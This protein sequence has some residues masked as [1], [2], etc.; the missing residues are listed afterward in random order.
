MSSR[1]R[2][3]LI[4]VYLGPLP[5][6][7]AYF[8]RSAAANPG[9]DFLVALDDP[10][11]RR[12]RWPDNVRPLPVSRTELEARAGDTLGAAID[13][14]DP[15]KLC[16]LKPLY[17]ELFADRLA[18]HEFWG[19]VDLDVIWGDLSRYLTEEILA[20]HDLISADP[21]RICGP[22]TILRN[23]PPRR[24]MVRSTPDLAELLRSPIPHAVDERQFDAHVKTIA[25]TGGCRCLFSHRPGGPPMQHYGADTP[26]APPARF[27]ASWRD[28]RLTIH[29]HGGESM[30]LHL[31][32]V[33][34]SMRCD[35]ADAW[36]RDTWIVTAEA[37][38]PWP[39]PR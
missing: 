11:A 34:G 16:D 9:V 3:A 36:G 33:A 25:A 26:G 13:L 19:F 38:L 14:G 21:R 17:G 28:G 15:R 20:D 37:I 1:R 4:A 7:F 6:T 23:D 5:P 2:I 39:M 30:M 32:R 27:P 35:P 24:S 18:G 12:L 29:A 22:F 8:L 10:D 31:L